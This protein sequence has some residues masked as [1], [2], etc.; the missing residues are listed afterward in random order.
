[1]KNAYLAAL[2]LVGTAAYASTVESVFKKDTV[3]PEDLKARLLAAVEE[4][5]ARVLTNYGLN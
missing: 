3:L 1:M 2:A 5:C 4:Q